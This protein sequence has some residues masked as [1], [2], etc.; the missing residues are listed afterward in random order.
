MKL[1]RDLMK[2]LRSLV[3]RFLV[4]SRA[5]HTNPHPGCIL[6]L[7]L[8]VIAVSGSVA[9]RAEQVSEGAVSPH[10]LPDDVWTPGSRVS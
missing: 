4:T 8:P 1:L 6:V 2:C 9:N 5:R 10:F 3:A 7:Y